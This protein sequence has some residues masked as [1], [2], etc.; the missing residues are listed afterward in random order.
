MSSRIGLVG[1]G[2]R[3]A[4]IYVPLLKKMG[5]DVTGFATRSESTRQRF[6][7]LTGLTPDT[8][9]NIAAASDVL[10]VCVS[11]DAISQVVK[12]CLQHK[13][14]VLMETPVTD[15]GLLEAAAQAGV[16]LG[17]LEQWPFLPLEQFKELLFEQ[18]IMSR[19]YLAV[20]DC[21]SFDYHAVAQLRSY[22][23]RGFDPVIVTGQ[24]V[25]SQMPTFLDNQ[26]NPC[27]ADDSWDLGTIKFSNGA[28][29]QHNFSYNC[30]RAPFRTI[31]SLRSYSKDG[32]IMT[33]KMIDKDDD[34]EILDFRRLREGGK[35]E[36]MQVYCRRSGKHTSSIEDLRVQTPG[37][38]SG[39][40]WTNPFSG[41]DD[42]ETALAT[43]IKA[44]QE[45]NVLYPAQQAFVDYV[46]I[47]AIKQAA[48]GPGALGLRRG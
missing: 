13:K 43:I 22:I 44:A 23:G 6:Q 31:Q 5:V 1:A 41:F 35:T 11:A 20:N 38:G 10:L 7:E 42:T 36:T 12:K 40:C 15:T 46:C 24:S 27:S 34:Y 17:C 21:R 32:S 47:S 37:R 48:A 26:G 19:P 4:N 30:K 18:G 45:G 14:L 33:G 39:L 2:K 3:M 9:S 25:V 28:I 29:I 16:T 8:L